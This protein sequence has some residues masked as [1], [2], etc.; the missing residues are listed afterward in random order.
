MHTGEGKRHKWTTQTAAL[1]RR[2]Q[3]VGPVTG[4]APA[5]RHALVVAGHGW[6]ACGPHGRVCRSVAPVAGQQ[7][8]GVGLPRLQLYDAITLQ[9]GGG[10]GGGAGDGGAPQWIPNLVDI[11]CPQGGLPC[12]S[13]RG[14]ADGGGFVL[15]AQ[16]LPPSSP[17]PSCVVQT[18]R[19]L[20]HHVSAAAAS[21]LPRSWQS[22]CT[23]RAPALPGTPRCRRQSA[24]ATSGA[25]GR[26]GVGGCSGWGGGGVGWGAAT[27]PAPSAGGT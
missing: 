10:G 26:G 3:E 4:R 5:G 27:H 21:P 19:N 11:A 16:T 2:Q 23:Q 7:V 20:Q 25:C 24:A 12:I 17:P 13:V 14:L 15:A 18:S 8:E 6:D 1:P 9:S 22:V